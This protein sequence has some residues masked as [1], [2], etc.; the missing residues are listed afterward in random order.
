M[1][2]RSRLVLR[3]VQATRDASLVISV[4]G[5]LDAV[6]TISN[7]RHPNA[8]DQNATVVET[9]G[10]DQPP[11]DIEQA[12]LTRLADQ[13]AGRGLRQHSDDDQ[14]D[15]FLVYC[16]QITTELSGI[17]RRTFEL[18]RWRTNVASAHRPYASLGGDVSADGTDP[19]APIPGR[20]SVEISQPRHLQLEPSTADAAE[21]LIQHGSVEPL[22]HHLL[23][24]ALSHTRTSPRSALVI[25]VAAL[26][27]G[28]KQLVADLVPDA[29]WL[30]EEVS[31][32]PLARM[33]RDY[34]PALPV[35][36]D[37]DGVVYP[38][39]KAVRTRVQGAV[40]ERN[41]VTHRGD[42]SIDHHELKLVLED[43]R[44][45]LY[46]FDFYS[47]QAWARQHL[48]ADFRIGL[49]T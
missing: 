20:F 34:L 43:T 8:A 35:R 46:L 13:G 49:G 19:W 15:P 39:P 33:L 29:R 32:P 4:G 47:G 12:L 31:S 10:T 28:F 30:I 16:T 2:F 3:D 38:P 22:G 45:L 48:S 25:G 17:G 41:R 18:V 26:E 11:P 37:F 6:V 24:E 21:P 42:A 5:S 44:D 27:T 23:R 14:D 1:H 7:G 9:V 36:N 40:E